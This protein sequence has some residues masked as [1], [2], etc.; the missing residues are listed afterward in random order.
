MFKIVWIAAPSKKK[1]KKNPGLLFTNACWFIS[2]STKVYQIS[3]FLSVII[4]T[5]TSRI[6]SSKWSIFDSHTFV[7]VSV[8]VH[9]CYAH[10]GV[11]IIGGVLIFLTLSAVKSRLCQRSSTQAVTRLHLIT[12]VT[13][14]FLSLKEK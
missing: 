14:S 5:T 12:Q 6:I 13:A 8:S 3:A 2:E 7:Q 9:L 1:T 10:K 4:H 11:C